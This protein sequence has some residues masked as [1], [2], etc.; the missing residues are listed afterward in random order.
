MVG[1]RVGSWT[2][3]ERFPIGW[4][5]YLLAIVERILGAIVTAI[6]ILGFT[7]LVR[8]DETRGER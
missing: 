8:Q 3:I 6:A 4:V 2:V 5:L 7:G 1:L